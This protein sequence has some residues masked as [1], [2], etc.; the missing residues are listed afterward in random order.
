MIEADV[1][2]SSEASD[3]AESSLASPGP[4]SGAPES[5]VT[6]GLNPPSSSPPEKHDA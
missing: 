5:M 6:A 3:D 2:A 4:A 1:V